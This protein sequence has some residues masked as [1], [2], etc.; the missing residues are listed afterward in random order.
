MILVIASHAY[1][2]TYTH[3]LLMNL[4]I[5]DISFLLCCVPF[6]AH[7][8]H[9]LAWVFGDIACKVIQ[10]ILYVTLY[11][12][13]WTLVS[14]AIVRYYVV[15]R[16]KKQMRLTHIRPMV[17][18]T[19][20]MWITIALLNIP[21]AMSHEVKSIGNYTYC[22]IAD[23]ATKILQV[24]LFVFGYLLPLSIITAAYSF[25]LR[26]LCGMEIGTR[27]RTRGLHACKGILA[28]VI[29]FTVAWLPYHVHELIRVY[30]QIPSGSTY[31]VMRVFWY[32]LAYSNSVVNPLIYNYVCRDF[33]EAFRHI[34]FCRNSNCGFHSV[35]KRQPSSPQ[36]MRT[37]TATR[38]QRAPEYNELMIEK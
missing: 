36:T 11:T 13:V 16:S 30:G 1:M 24:S 27:R 32:C 33:R 3:V 35:L 23:K 20:C 12:T 9:A 14:I 2:R 17:I 19:I 21:T 15:T 26:I 29:C 25:V 34:L 31:E 28:V 8:F 7:K 10:F 6:E 18:Y 22:G 38:L 5:A 4:A 37:L